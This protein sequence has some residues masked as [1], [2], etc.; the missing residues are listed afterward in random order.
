MESIKLLHVEEKPILVNTVKTLLPE[1]FK[2]VKI[3]LGLLLQYR[4]GLNMLGLQIDITYISDESEELMHYQAL[5]TVE[6][7]E[8]LSFLE[9]QPV[10]I[11]I[12]EYS[13]KMFDMALG[14]ARSSISKKLQGTSIASLYLPVF[15]PEDYTK[16]IGVVCLDKLNH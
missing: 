10:N 16:H 12:S 6:D 14:Y 2:K 4:I 7:E 8:W 9:T 1:D 13:C 15:K 11:Q 3:R 5:F